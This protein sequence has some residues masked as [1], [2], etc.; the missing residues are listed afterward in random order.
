MIILA[1]LLVAQ[2]LPGQPCAS[3]WFPADL[4]TWSPFTD[5]DA[6]Y[7]RSMIPLATRS[8]GDT[9]CNAHAIPGQAGIT[10]IGI[11]Y[12]S[13]S[14]N[15][16]QGGL[17]IDTYA[18]G[19]WQ[20]IEN[21][22]FW[23]GSA[24]EGLI[25]A[26]SPEVTDAAHRNGVPVYGTVFFPPAQYGGQIQWVWDF[27]QKDGDGFPV[28]DKLIEAA[29]YYGFDG[30][31]INQ[32]T[33]GGNVQLAMDMRDM[34]LYIQQNSDLGIQWYDAMTESGAI[35]WQ[36]ALNAS[37]DWFFQHEGQVV[38]DEMFLNFWWTPAGLTNSAGLATSLGRSPYELYAG[39]DVQANGYNTGV[40]WEGPFPEGADHRVSL[41]F[42]CPNWTYTNSSSHADFYTR[43][44]RFWVGANRD[45]GNTVTTHPWKG[46]AHYIPAMTPVTALPFMTNFN[47]G[48]GYRCAV[49]GLV[50]SEN[51]WHNR[52]QMDVLPTWRYMAR[53]NGEP[54][55]PELDWDVPYY[56]GSC[57]KVSGEL[58][59][60][61]TTMLYLYK[62]DAPV[63]GDDSFVIVW[64]RGTS[65]LPSGI[66][67]ALS[68]SQDPMEFEYFSVPDGTGEGW[69]SWQF[70]LSSLAGDTLSIIALRFDS[71]TVINDYEVRI[72]RLGV[73]RGAQ[74]VPSAPGGLLVEQFNQIDDLSGTVRLRWNASPGSIYSYNVY[75]LNDDD[76]RTFLWA[77]PG[78]A[79]FVPLVTRPAGRDTTTI[80]VEAVS[81]EFGFSAPAQTHVIW[82]TT[83]MET[84]GVPDAPVFL[85]GL[86]NPVSGVVD[87][88]FSVPTAGIVELAVLDLAGRVVERLQQGELSAGQHTVV[89]DTSEMA[90]GVYFQVLAAPGGVETRKC[91]VL[92]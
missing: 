17:G 72:G 64:N 78:N 32:E 2:T 41:G 90:A 30:W 82:N 52:S 65:G 70:P 31:F 3:Y 47:T 81:T 67:V 51:Q 21:L 79:C 35:S 33:G 12:P 4:L 68:T 59:P 91:M 49:E 66:E 26:P 13:T 24:G 29:E 28:A 20:Y 16:S 55:Y 27:V 7:N 38:S 89:W 25:L 8:A 76:S 80:L 43:D 14:F 62:T 44:N 75:G 84:E 86:S 92:R 42:Y 46:M 39:V 1:A 22:T 50:L 56:G 88:G 60:S 61:N 73:V 18:F 36:N 85:P 63:Q 9:Q 6:P 83:G 19:Y 15:P 53:S 37:N 23:G 87:I 40:N 69:N 48:Q 34:M 77:T 45:P 57:L 11:M 71:P 74:D 5:P 54:L 58:S 10:S